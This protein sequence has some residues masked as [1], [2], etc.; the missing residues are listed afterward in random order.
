MAAPFFF[1]LF[2]TVAIA[3]ALGLV[4][5]RSPISSA[6][7][8]VLNLFCIAGLYVT[9]NAVFIGVIQV[10]VYAGAIMVL[11]LFV[12][13]LLNLEAAPQL[14]EVDWR[15]GVAFA[16]AMVVMAQLAYLVAAG[17]DAVPV[18]F[19]PEAT[20]HTGSAEV[21]AAE[22]FTRYALQL[23]VIALLLL[24]ATIGAVLLA[25]RRFE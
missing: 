13:M 2:A 9:L 5:S 22:L 6:L 16:L 24:A 25:Q 14:Q 23:E 20:A 10:L 11:F 19:T 18:S 7:W 15:K 1:F 21:L 8:L 17:L 3:A 12:I 4:L